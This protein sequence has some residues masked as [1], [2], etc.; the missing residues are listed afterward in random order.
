MRE[1]TFH[2]I[3]IPSGARDLHFAA[4]CI[5]LAP[6]GMTTSKE[7]VSSGLIFSGE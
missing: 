5:S 2:E 6:L 4:D 1:Y 3:V 7:E